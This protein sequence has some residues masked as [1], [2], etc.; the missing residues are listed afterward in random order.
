MSKNLVTTLLIITLSLVAVYSNAQAQVTVVR[1]GQEN[2]V[3][4]I[5][6]STLY[7]AA[8]GVLLGLALTLVVDEDTGDILKWS[9]VGGTFGGFLFGIYHVSTRPEPSAAL[10]QFDAR[11]LVKMNVPKPQL[12]LNRDRTVDFRVSL[13]SLSL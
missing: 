9:F 11:G 10:L 3:I 1:G 12:R 8:T 2:P 7:G 5:A 4:S 6:K 13:M